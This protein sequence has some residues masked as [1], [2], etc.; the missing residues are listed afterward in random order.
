M[1]FKTSNKHEAMFV[2]SAF[3]ILTASC[4]ALHEARLC[5]FESARKA[6]VEAAPVKYRS[7]N[8]CSGSIIMDKFAKVD[9]QCIEACYKHPECHSIY[10]HTK[11]KYC[12]L[13]RFLEEPSMCFAHVT[14]S[15]AYHALLDRGQF[16]DMVS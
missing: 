15:D 2:T 6:L 1:I 12:I 8:T 9:Y 10:F 13:W 3:F 11:S 14:T 4:F 5:H 16:R 7:A